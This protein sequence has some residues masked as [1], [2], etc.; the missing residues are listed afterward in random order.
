MSVECDVDSWLKKIDEDLDEIELRLE[1]LKSAGRDYESFSM[2]YDIGALS[3][4]K[5]VEAHLLSL[6]LH[7]EGGE[8]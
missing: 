3:V 5:S 4:L 6:K 1:G 8:K 7:Y 2:A